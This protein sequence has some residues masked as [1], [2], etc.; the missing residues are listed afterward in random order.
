MKITRTSL[1]SGIT[2]TRDLDITEEQ[3]QRFV[4]GELVQKAFP[5][6]S[7]DEREFIVTGITPHEWDH[8]MRD[9]ESDPNDESS[10]GAR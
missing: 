9:D 1:L 5:H 8:Y 6:L 7:P 3:Y 10:A 4:Q 2:R